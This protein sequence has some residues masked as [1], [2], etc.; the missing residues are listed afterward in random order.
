MGRA[1]ESENTMLDIETSFLKRPDETPA[2]RGF[3]FDR[4]PETGQTSTRCP[5]EPHLLGRSVL[6]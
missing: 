6:G 1:V 2:S 4:K 3:C 5:A